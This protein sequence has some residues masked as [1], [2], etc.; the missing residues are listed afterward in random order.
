MRLIDADG[1]KRDLRGYNA[2][3]EQTID[4]QPTVDAE[5]VVRC[6]D[7][8]YCRKYNEMWRF[9]KLDVLLCT[10]LYDGDGEEVSAEDYCSR[11]ERKDETD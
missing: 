3:V 5:P 7:C 4:R 10:R 8:Y 9:P 6:K 2:Y 1:L 11:G